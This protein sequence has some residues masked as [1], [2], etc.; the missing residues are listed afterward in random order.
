MLGR[1][2]ISATRVRAL[3]GADMERAG[4]GS[5]YWNA[6]LGSVP[7]DCWHAG[8]LRKW[9]EDLPAHVREGRGLILYGDYGTGKTSLTVVIIKEVLAR[10]GTALKVS[11]LDLAKYAIEATPFDEDET[12]MRRMASVDLLVIDDLAAEHESAWSRSVVEKVVRQR[13]ENRGSLV[14]ST[15]A[16][17]NAPDK[18]AR[19]AQWNTMFGSSV[20]EVLSEAVFP[21]KVSGVNWRGNCAEELHKKMGPYLANG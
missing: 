15:N 18:A 1:S 12:I 10:G 3:N 20:F 17:A 4:V 2:S 16:G 14:I 21:V 11:A 9:I 8:F 7:A 6:T 13:V 19:R 5:R